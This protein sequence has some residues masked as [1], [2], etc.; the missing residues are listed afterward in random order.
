MSANDLA[1]AIEA[2]EKLLPRFLDGFDDSNEVTQRPGLPNHVAWNLGHLALTMHRAAER[3][4]DETYPLEGDPEPYAFGSTPS[5]TRDDYPALSEL[6]DRYRRSLV[7]LAEAVRRCGDEGLARTVTWGRGTTTTTA[8]D[9][10]MRMVWHN[11]L[12][13]GQIIDLRRVL[14]LEPVIK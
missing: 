4:A 6:T 14:G 1:D 9:L 2:T 3:I 13:C 8:R 12:H 11:G 7:L 10:A 5:D